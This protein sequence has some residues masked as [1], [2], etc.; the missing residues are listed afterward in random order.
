MYALDLV[1][2]RQLCEQRLRL[3]D[4]GHFG[5]RC[6]ALKRGRED[7]VRIGATA[8]RLIELGERERSAQAE[9]ARPL[10]LSDGNG[11][12]VGFFGGRRIRRIAL[13][14]R[15]AANAMQF[16]IEGALASPIR[17]R[18]RVVEDGNSAVDIVG[19]SFGF[20]EGNLDE[21]VEHQGILVAQKLDPVTHAL[22]PTF[23]RAGQT[24]EKNPIRSPLRQIVFTRES[25]EF[26]GVRCGTREVPAH[27]FEHC[28]E[29]CPKCARADIG[30]TR[31]PRLSTANVRNRAF[32]VAQRPQYKPEVEHCRDA[33]V[34]AEA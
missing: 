11:G 33:D 10:T 5:L 21:S 8:G 13:Q 30:E 31:D 23:L 34:V 4:L 20:C 27:Q 19:A 3:R 17:R 28:R 7:G 24:F 26:N 15:F 14:Q 32:D 12:P 25:S 18:Q 6:K 9:A 2:L 22:E 1:G 29:H 16:C